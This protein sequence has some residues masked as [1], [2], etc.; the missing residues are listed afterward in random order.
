MS[1][2]LQN[3]SSEAMSSNPTNSVQDGTTEPDFPLF[4]QLPKEIRF[5]IWKLAAT[6]QAR[7]VEITDNEFHMEI[8]SPPTLFADFESEFISKEVL[9]KIFDGQ[10]FTGKTHEIYFCPE[11]DTIA[12]KD[13]RDFSFPQ[14]RLIHGPPNKAYKFPSQPECDSVRILELEEDLGMWMYN[15]VHFGS[16]DELILRTVNCPD[17]R[18]DR[19]FLEATQYYQDK[20]AHGNCTKVPKITIRLEQGLEIRKHSSVIMQDI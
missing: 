6:N 12:F 20:L 3:L 7:R 18:R 11:K 16:L 15:A 17:D 19:V 9:S 5:M 1:D 10:T 14:D 2:S 8:S 13:I 4:R